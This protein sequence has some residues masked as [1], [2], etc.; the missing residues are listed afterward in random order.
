MGAASVYAPA[1]PTSWCQST[2]EKVVIMIHIFSLHSAAWSMVAVLLCRILPVR[3]CKL[4]H[5]G[6]AVSQDRLQ[7]RH[8]ED[9]QK[10]DHAQI[11][12]NC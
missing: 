4:A 8:H 5:A 10:R 2:M 12:Q 9:N 6:K 3:K 7:L 1:R 11:L